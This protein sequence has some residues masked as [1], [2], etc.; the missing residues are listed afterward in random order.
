MPSEAWKRGTYSRK[1][2]S[3]EGKSMTKIFLLQKSITDIK[4]PV[5]KIPY[6]TNAVTL[7]DLLYEMVEKN[8]KGEREVTDLIALFDK[9]TERGGERFVYENQKAKFSVP[10]MKEFVCTAFEDKVFLVKNVTKQIL[11]ESLCRNLDVSENDEIVLI[12][13]KYMRGMI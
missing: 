7:R 6:E 1:T 8:A 5:R 9:L 2:E 13:L 4:S 10:Q 3:E 12:K 11:Y